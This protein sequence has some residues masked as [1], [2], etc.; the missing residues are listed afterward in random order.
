VV[1]TLPDTTDASVITT[2]LGEAGYDNMSAELSLLMHSDEFDTWKV[3]DSMV[4][5]FAR[6]HEIAG[7]VDRERR[8]TT[9]FRQ[10]LGD[11]VPAVMFESDP[12]SSF[13][14]PFLGWETVRGVQAQSLRGTFAA[15]PRSA[16]PT[17]VEHVA[18][19]IGRLHAIPTRAARE[20]GLETEDVSEERPLTPDVATVEHVRSVVGDAIDR[21]LDQ[22][23]PLEFGRSVTCHRD[24]KGEHIFLSPSLDRVTS[25]IDW[26]DACVTDPALDVAGIVICWGPSFARAVVAAMSEP[27]RLPRAGSSSQDGA[28]FA[29]SMQFRGARKRI[30][31]SSSHRSVSRSRNQ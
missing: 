9:L 10:H 17:L 27:M 20:H 23:S 8:A 1:T 14:Y 3:G 22:P 21:F 24:L 31:G 30:P 2:I 28:C 7:K 18:S 25:L 15:P 4:V 12:V 6:T 5:K 13:P 16:V 11:L 29:T 26:A 19:V